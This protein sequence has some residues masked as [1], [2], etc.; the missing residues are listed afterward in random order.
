V[1]KWHLLVEK[2]VWAVGENLVVEIVG[3][4]DES[5]M[6]L[7]NESLNKWK[8]ATVLKLFASID[9]RMGGME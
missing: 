1:G 8:V 7:V 4:V 3:G 5:L 9:L 2:V 6:S